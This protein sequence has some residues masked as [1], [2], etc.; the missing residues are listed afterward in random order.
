[1]SM[2]EI[3]LDP[4]TLLL[5]LNTFTRQQVWRQHS[6]NQPLCTGEDEYPGKD[7]PNTVM[8]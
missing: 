4:A 8:P 5:T 1:M 3:A 7:W 6:I 2:L